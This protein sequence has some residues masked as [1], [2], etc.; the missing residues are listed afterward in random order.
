MAHTIID[1]DKDL[2]RF[3]RN[4]GKYRMH[5]RD[6]KIVLEFEKHC[7]IE[8][9]SVPRRLKL[10]RV[11]SIFSRD[12]LKKRF[13]HATADDI[14]D[15]IITV[16]QHNY[17]PWTKHDVKVVVKKFFK[18][19]VWGRDGLNRTGYP[20]IVARISTSM[21]KRDKVRIQASDVLS[22]EEVKRLIA[23]AT[24]T[25]DRA[26]M[27]L[28]YELGARISEIGCMKIG[29]VSKDE[30]SFICSLNGKT[31]PRTSRV[32]LGA[33][34]L[35]AWLNQHP[36]KDNLQ[37]PLWGTMQQGKWTRSAYS[38]LRFRVKQLSREAGIRKRVYPHLFRHTRITHI[39]S[40]NHMNQDQAKLF[41]GFSKDSTVMERT[42]SHLISKDANDAVLRMY[43][44][45]PK[46]RDALPA[47]DQCGMCRLPNEP[48]STF[49]SRCGYALDGT[50][51]IANQKRSKKAGQRIA[52]FLRD[53]ENQMVFRKWIQEEIARELSRALPQQ[54]SPPGEPTRARRAA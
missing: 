29:D 46:E 45:V 6:E 4:I 18:F 33:A 7:V 24:N 35:T 28:L 43:G 14:F 2:V 48:G 31:G 9:L 32:I 27:T 47:P 52:N 11:L 26:F 1:Y 44:I 50:A 42:Y 37:A 12:F 20:P 36:A 25:Q 17:A 15:A 34:A 16:E 51:A 53:P 13:E 22:V 39:R 54:S 30:Y 5:K 21:R 38:R 23:T 10:C 40:E 8:G 49:C 41:F 3:R 19:L